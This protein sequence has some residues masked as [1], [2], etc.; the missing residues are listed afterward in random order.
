MRPR[1]LVAAVAVVACI[2]ACAEKPK[3]PPGSAG[4]DASLSRIKVARAELLKVWDSLDVMRVELA[5]LED[6]QRLTPAQTARK[7]DLSTQVKGAEAQFESAYG[8]DQSA[9]ADFLNEALNSRPG[10]D[11]T[12]AALR[13]YLDS[14]LRNA[15]DFI[16]HSG[17][18][19]RAIEL[20]ETAR[21]YYEAVGAGVPAD[22][23]AALASARD[24]RFVTRAHFDQLRKGMTARD[25][26]AL[27]GVPFYANVRHSEV[28]GKRVASWLYSR[29]DG[30]I[31]ALY[32]DDRGS[33]YAWKWDAKR[34][35]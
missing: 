8:A 3:E 6:A 2:V 26:K 4:A 14:A 35:E 7:A 34:G 31:A 30:E 32:F 9:L 19:R 17:D 22:L 18:Y 11:S 27:V 1:P 12:L 24:F 21:S 16:A 29:E 5:A 20:L 25:V 10:A 13:L 28:G 33:L 15:R 23:S